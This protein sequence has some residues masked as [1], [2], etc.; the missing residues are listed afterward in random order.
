VAADDPP[1]GLLEDPA[2]ELAVAFRSQ[3]SWSQYRPAAGE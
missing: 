2:V 1:P 3:T